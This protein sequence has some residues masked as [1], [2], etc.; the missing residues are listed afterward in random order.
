ML[1]AR[2]HALWDPAGAED[3]LAAASEILDLARAAGDDVR[4]RHGMFWRFVALMELGRVGEAESALAAF[5][6]AAIAAGDS[7]AVVMATAR[8]AMLAT[9]RGRFD[10][11]ARLIEQ[12]AADGARAGLPDTE[13]LVAATCTGRSP[14]FCH[15]PGGGAVH[16][17]SAA[18]P[19]QAA[20]RALYGGERGCLAGD[21][22]AGGKAQAEMDRVLP[23]VLA[24]SG[25]RWLG[26]A[27]M[28]AFVAAQTGDISAATQL[29]EVCCRYQGQLVVLG[30]ANSCMGPVSLPG[31]AG[32][33]AR[34]LATAVDLLAGPSASPKGGVGAL[35]G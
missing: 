35:P 16:R 7:Q 28:L 32:H 4:E 31:A 19:G 22:R 24:G 10:Q 25:P 26:A 6:R 12:V 23:A 14:R 15:R 27:A 18:S 17:G 13:R 20:A 33:T 11:A 2:L 8:H 21:A 1:D 29:R 3:R 30:G 5:E 9:F 34:R